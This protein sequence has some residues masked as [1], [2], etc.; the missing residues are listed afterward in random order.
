MD[1]YT[2]LIFEGKV[3]EY[4]VGSVGGGGRYDNLINDLAGVQI[5]AVGFGIGFDRTVEAADQLGLIPTENMG[6]QVL[7]TVFSEITATNSTQIA[8]QLRDAGIRVEL[9]PS[10]TDSLGKQFQNAE[11]KGIPFAIVIGEDEI[12]NNV[13]TVKNIQ[14]RD[15]QTLSIE[16]FVKTLQ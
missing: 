16:K 12:N 3:P 8:Q 13:I 11:Q 14:T 1:Y 7:V 15:Q 6:T 5:P 4:T 2:G 9:Y 10:T